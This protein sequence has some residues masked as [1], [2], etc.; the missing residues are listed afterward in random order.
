LARSGVAAR[1]ASKVAVKIG[2]AGFSR[3]LSS[4][5]G[6]SFASIDMSIEEAL[7]YAD[8]YTD[9]GA[10]QIIFAGIRLAISAME[11]F[12]VNAGQE[13]VLYGNIIPW[14]ESLPLDPD[15]CAAQ[16]STVYSEFG[17][18]LEFMSIT[19]DTGVSIMEDAIIRAKF[20][21]NVGQILSFIF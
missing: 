5:I 7:S 1:I 8:D 3:A 14:F 6:K 21:Q 17:N 20:I 18:Y 15:D 10:E 16:L 11:G 2:G 19:I 4:K 13:S 12:P 9:D